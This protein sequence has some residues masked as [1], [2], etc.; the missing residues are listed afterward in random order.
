MKFRNPNF[1][2]QGERIDAWTDDEAE[3]NML[4]QLFQS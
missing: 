2:R 3:S 4:T 1:F